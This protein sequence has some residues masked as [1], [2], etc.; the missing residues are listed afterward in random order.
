MG[1]PDVEDD[2]AYKKRKL[3]GMGAIEHSDIQ[4]LFLFLIHNTSLAQM[5]LPGHLLYKVC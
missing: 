2:S 1:E 4:V 3:N 5:A